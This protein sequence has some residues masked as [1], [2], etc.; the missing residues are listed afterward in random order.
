MRKKKWGILLVALLLMGLLAGCTGKSK[1]STEANGEYQKIELV[2][3]VNGTDIQI[4]SLVANKFAQLVEEE[5]GGSVTV[6]VYPNDQL[7]GGNATKGIEMIAGGSVDLAAYATCTMAVIDEQL[8]CAT[9]PWIFDD[10]T[11]A[12]EIIDATGGEYY[13]ERLSGKGI[14][15]LDSFHNGFRQ[16]TNGK[17]AVKTPADVKGLKIRVPGSE[18]F[19]K[20]FRTLGADPVAMSW[21]EVFT[22]IQQGTID[23]QENGVSV[24]S[25]S[26]MSEIQDYMTLWNY[27]YE[28]DLFVANTE[29]WEALEPKTR[30]LLQEKATEACEWGRDEVEQQ[31]VELVQNFRDA[32]MEVTELTDEQLDEFKAVMKDTR[33]EFIKKYGE[34]AQK[35]FQID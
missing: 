14:T 5:S 1:A 20:F 21:S 12:R 19:M 22:A 7:A 24:T 28:N 9:I 26:K 33:Q 29:I 25:S 27:S 6:V 31:E 34:K 10:Y 11:D 35:A 3:A 13:A 4:D 2:M 23:G 18:V 16:I 17:R 8:A 15:Y 32:G 30:K